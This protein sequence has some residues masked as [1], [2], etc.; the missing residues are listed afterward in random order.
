MAFQ[1]INTNTLLAGDVSP[2]SVDIV[3][4]NANPA[5][6][7]DINNEFVFFRM[8]LNCDPRANNDPTKLDNF[9]WG[10][11]IKDLAGIPLFSIRVNASGNVNKVQVFEAEFSDDSKDAF[12]GSPICQQ[13]IQLGTNVFVSLA[14][15]NFGGDPDFFLDFRVPLSCFPDNFFN[16]QHIFC[17]FTSTNG[18]NINKELPPPYTKPGN[19]N[20]PALCGGAP[21]SEE[22]V[23]LVKTVTP[24][25]GRTCE[26][27]TFTVTITATNISNQTLS[28]TIT[29]VVNAQFVT[30]DDKIRN[31]TVT[32]Q[33]PGA[34]QQFMY[35]ITGNFPIAGTFSFNM[36]TAVDAAD[37][38]IGFVEG[39]DVVITPCRGL[40]FS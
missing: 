38:V 39:P 10:I 28:Y 2:C 32:N 14:G 5:L 31:F 33:A 7:M 15:S 22:K 13:N 6:F 1:P 40:I 37:N 9:A 29:D 25:T 8:R 12:V 3:G 30:L 19:S 21:P 11:L 17:G 34:S 4:N 16:D 27:Q 18:N 23:R 24:L 26:V 35:M 36:A 20:N